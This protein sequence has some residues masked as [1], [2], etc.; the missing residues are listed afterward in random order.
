M[1]RLAPGR[2]EDEL[3]PLQRELVDAVFHSEDAEEGARAFAEKRPAQ[4][5][6]R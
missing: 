5:T 3:W 2:S 4:W 1:L 6:G